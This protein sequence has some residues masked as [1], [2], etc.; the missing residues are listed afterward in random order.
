MTGKLK[1]LSILLLTTLILTSALLVFNL[2]PAASAQIPDGI[3]RNEVFVATTPL[4]TSGANPDNMNSWIPGAPQNLVQ[5]IIYEPLWL[6][7]I[8]G[9]KYISYLASDLPTYS[10]N[11]TTLTTHLRQG[12]YWSDGQPFTADDVVFTINLELNYTGLTSSAFIRTWVKD[13]YKTDDY[14]V[15]IDLKQPNPL[16]YISSSF[17]NIM[18]KHVWE[19]V[20][21][22]VAYQNNP[23]I[24]TSPYVL[25]SY[26]TNGQWVL[27]KLRD[28]WDRTATGVIFGQPQPKYLLYEFY[29]PQNP[30]LL[31]AI[32]NHDIDATETTT[33]LLS[34]VKQDNSAITTFS[35]TFP[36]SWQ[37]GLYTA[38]ESFN[39]AKY[40]YNIT[41]VRWALTLALNI[42]EV[43]IN[44]Y[45]GNG[46]IATYQALT[47]PYLAPIF[48]SR[49]L[50][51]LENFQLSDGYKP[52]DTNSGASA[53]TAYAQSQG[54]SDYTPTSI[55]PGWWKY[56]PV[57]A[58][59]LLKDNGFSQD[60]NGNWLLPNGTR[61]TID[62]LGSSDDPSGL[63]LQMAVQTEW[64][65]FG[66]NLK[67]ETLTSS[68]LASRTNL[69]DYDIASGNTF[70][71]QFYD[72]WPYWQVFSQKYI[73]PIGTVATSNQIRW[74]NA[75]FSSLLDQLAALPPDD[76][77]VL[78]ITTRLTQ[79]SFEQ[80]PV[81]NLFDVSRM[82]IRDNTYWT[83]EPTKENL[84]WEP[85]GP[86]L[87]V[88]GPLLT[89]I[90]PTGSTGTSGSILSSPTNLAVI[91]AV[92]VVVV[93]ILGFVVVRRAKTKKLKLAKSED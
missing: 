35:S 20:G 25:Q 34:T 71:S 75:E 16:F 57:E 92:P 67:T 18:P 63:R 23:P 89:S 41:E 42:T 85:G 27:Y 37:N 70:S 88:Y 87:M 14:T 51:W 31:V 17:P 46:V 22:P 59:K 4:Y 30:N 68:V 65:K 13:V 81:I 38:G 29:A 93:A 49:L 36:F 62:F 2:A 82:Y 86:G 5:T 10:N 84:Y 53:L 90:H 50:P 78:D 39:N 56:D 77:K 19:N 61:W 32:K 48:E 7:N 52:F 6:L 47:K 15:V 91:V 24:G 8:T 73:Q 28:D 80:Q 76:P 69:G 79:I 40:P 83:G 9:Q 12:I 33:D 60:S 55:S 66:V 74:S 45:Q 72:V 3:P 58:A 64:Q 21:N 11:Y 54:Y 1:K 43:N 44:A 26:D